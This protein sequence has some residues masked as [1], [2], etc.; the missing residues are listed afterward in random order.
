MSHETF[1]FV[2]LGM[3]AAF[4]VIRWGLLSP[5]QS[6][7]FGLVAAAFALMAG[8]CAWYAWAE[9]PRSLPWTLAYGVLALLGGAAARKQ[10]RR[11]SVT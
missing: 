11:R 8:L 6:V 2:F 9:P 1:I 7:A 10:F 4:C 3:I 5:R